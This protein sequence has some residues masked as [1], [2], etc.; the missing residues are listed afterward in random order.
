MNEDYNR[1]SEEL[2][3][4]DEERRIA[5]A[6]RNAAIARLVQIIYFLTAALEVLLLIRVFLR[7][8]GAN[9]NNEFARVISNLSNPFVA[10]F[11]NLFRKPVLG[12]SEVLDINALVAIVAYSILAWLIGQLIWLIGSRSR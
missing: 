5:V 3:L 7:L 11:A 2:R 12:S 6:N 9:L 1:R 4:Q 8:S 10:P